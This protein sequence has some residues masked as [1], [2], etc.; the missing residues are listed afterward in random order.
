MSTTPPRSHRIP[1]TL[2]LLAVAS[3]WVSDTPAAAAPD[4]EVIVI[5]TVNEPVPIV[6]VGQ[7]ASQPFQVESTIGVT[8]FLH[9]PLFSVPAGQRAVIETVSV[10]VIF[11]DVQAPGGYLSVETTANAMQANHFLVL[12]SQGTV[13]ASETRTANH[14]VRLYA[15]PGTQI[16]VNGALQIGSELRVTLSGHLVDLP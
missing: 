9:D 13:L 7:V 5:N 4:K 14:S 10:L 11:P 8:G 15:D 3:A 2:V 16:F 1:K 12:A 6:D